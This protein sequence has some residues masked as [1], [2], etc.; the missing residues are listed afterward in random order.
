MKK[1]K[2]ILIILLLIVLLL[3]AGVIVVAS[4]YLSKVNI[5]RGE[6][7]ISTISE[8]DLVKEYASEEAGTEPDSPSEAIEEMDKHLNEV[9]EGTDGL[10]Q[11]KDV[12]NIL[13]IGCDSRKKNGWGRS[14]VMILLSVNQKKETIYLTSIMRD[15]YTSIEGYQNNRMNAAYAFGGA[16]LLMNTVEQNFGIQ[17]DKYISVDFYSFVDVIDLLGGVDINVTNA[18]VVEINNGVRYMNR[19]NKRPIEEGQLS[20]SGDVHLNGT[21]ALSYARIRHLSGGDFGR[22]ERQRKILQEVIAKAKSADLATLTNLLDKALPMVTTN[23]DEMEIL[24]LATKMPSWLTYDVEPHRIPVDG[25]YKY[26][27][28]RG[29]SVLGVD[30]EKNREYLKE[31]LYME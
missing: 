21:Q 16:K 30:F 22:T 10:L 17:V 5:D 7:N 4:H 14:D 31:V 24:S 8:V 2:K 19:L 1:L 28:V 12:Y 20:Q 23:L 11:S 29:M 15:V 26:M 25:T 6:E 18:E 9:V 3:L 27:R 13:L